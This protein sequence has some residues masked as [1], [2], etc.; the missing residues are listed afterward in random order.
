M[1]YLVYHILTE[2]RHNKELLH[3][4]NQ[5]KEYIYH[6]IL[7]PAECCD[8]YMYSMNNEVIECFRSLEITFVRLMF[9]EWRVHCIYC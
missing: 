6:H 8:T 7:V 5:D 2:G 1:Y 4:I 3:S 9:E